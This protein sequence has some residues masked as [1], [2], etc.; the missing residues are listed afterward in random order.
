[1][2]KIRN[3]V[4]MKDKLMISS[5]EKEKKR[6]SLRCS[7]CGRIMIFGTMMNGLCEKCADRLLAEASELLKKSVDFKGKL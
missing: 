1:M 5:R 2:K 6:R 4:L 3:K 7:R